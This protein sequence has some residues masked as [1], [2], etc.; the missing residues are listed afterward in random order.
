MLTITRVKDVG[1]RFM[2]KISRKN[3]ILA[4]L[5]AACL[6][7]TGTLMATAPK[8]DPN[9]IEEKNWPVTRAVTQARTLSPELHLFGR[10]ET[11]R[12][13]KLSA[14][15]AAEVTQL[16][17][18]EGQRVS[19]GQILVSLD[20]SEEELLLQQRSADLADS[21]AQLQL[22]LRDIETD[23][24]VLQHMQNLH[25]LTISK[26]GRLQTLNSKNLIATERL[27]DTQQEVARQGIQLARQQAQVDNNPQRVSQ[28]QAAVDRNLA[29]LENQRINVQRADIRAPFDGRISRLLV[30]PGDRVQPGQVLIS[31]Y[32]SNALQIR[33]PVP[34]SAVGKM[35]QA[36]RDGS[37]INAKI[38]GHKI[39]ATLQQ[40]AS[41]VSR[42]KSGVDA[43]FSVADENGNLE[44]GRA[45]EL[46]ITMPA[47]EDVIAL[48][49]Q[50]VYGNKRVFLI[51][52]QRLSSIEVSP[53][54]QRINSQGELEIL[55]RRGAL[56]SGVAILASNL[57]KAST[58]LKVEVINKPVPEPLP[59]KIEE[60]IAAQ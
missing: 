19:A 7:S 24:E 10:V 5:I 26:A 9:V 44:L 20:R 32:D 35:K 60:V 21:E 41:E 49:L 50:S 27:E 2:G 38:N 25:A 31:L 51:E 1:L 34:S 18:S 33:V 52:D 55:V 47:I 53:I 12:H 11:P 23:K 42:G 39:K 3:R 30:S 15:I 36:L 4:G 28:A 54:G 37:T 13:A 40:L 8:H 6:V 59:E 29:R 17:T 56:E 14:A 46:A 22:V 57:P 58:G 45:V 43:L 48:P 16:L